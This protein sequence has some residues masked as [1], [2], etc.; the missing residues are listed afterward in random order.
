[1]TITDTFVQIISIISLLANSS[2]LVKLKVVRGISLLISHYRTL[3]KVYK[4]TND[5]DQSIAVFL[6][7][8]VVDEGGLGLM[9]YWANIGKH[10]D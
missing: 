6:A 2:A 8:L 10:I 5:H 9:L 3:V 7:A 4:I 1:M